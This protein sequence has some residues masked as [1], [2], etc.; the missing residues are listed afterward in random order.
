[1]ALA[2]VPAP[3]VVEKFEELMSQQFFVDNKELSLHLID[4]FEER[5]LE[6]QLEEIYDDLQY[7]I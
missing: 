4:Y 1:M 3:Y 5:E 2:F 7:L 6:D